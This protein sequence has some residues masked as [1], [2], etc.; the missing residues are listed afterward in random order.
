MIIKAFIIV[1]NES[2]IIRFTI[3]H[4]QKFCTEVHILDNYSTDNTREIALG[5]GCHVQL[6]GTP[7]VLDDRCYLDIKNNIWK[8]H[9]DA[10]YVIVCDA[11]EILYHIERTPRMPVYKAVGYDMFSEALPAHSWDEINRGFRS[12]MYDKMIMFSPRLVR[13]INYSF[14]CH[15]ALPVLY[16][17]MSG[18]A[19]SPMLRHMRYIG[20]VERLIA[21]Y[22]RF[23]ER[24]SKYNRDHELGQH[25]LSDS[26]KIRMNWAYASKYAITIK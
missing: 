10:D 22:Q 17:R 8:A 1:Y 4:Y 14:G 3:N 19:I 6:F 12:P 21:R 11:D 15:T 23:A 25:Y 24:L 5:M 7:G 13:E 18:V 26:E 9:T 20:K 16:R 2:D